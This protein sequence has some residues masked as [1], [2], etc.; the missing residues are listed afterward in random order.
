MYTLNH[1]TCLAKRADTAKGITMRPKAQ[2]HTRLPGRKLVSAVLMFTG[3]V[4][5]ALG[6]Y[7]ENRLILNLGLLVT[8]AGVL[9]GILFLVILRDHGNR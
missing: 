6:Y 1:Q 9:T 5:L 8:L 4:L 2:K 3:I 7:Q